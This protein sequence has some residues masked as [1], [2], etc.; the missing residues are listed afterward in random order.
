[1]DGFY[2]KIKSQPMKVLIYYSKLVSFSSAPWVSLL[3]G[4]SNKITNIPKTTPKI[5]SPPKTLNSPAFDALS[6]I[7]PATL[8]PKPVAAQYTPIISAMYLAGANFVKKDSETGDKHNSPI[9]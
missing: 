4:F 7:T 8:F 6:P 3:R 2:S 9:V 1:M 5:K